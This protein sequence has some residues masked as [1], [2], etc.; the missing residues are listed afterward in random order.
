MVA[1]GCG[2][3]AAA[4]LEVVLERRPGASAQPGDD[5]RTRR[6]NAV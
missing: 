1:L 6:K 5:F 4:L 2:V 3:R